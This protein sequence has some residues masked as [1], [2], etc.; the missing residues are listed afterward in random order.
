MIY[1][2]FSVHLSLKSFVATNAQI[3]QVSKNLFITELLYF[4]GDTYLINYNA[5]FSF[6]NF[7]LF[8]LMQDLYFYAVHF[9]MHNYIYRIHVL[10]H[11]L[12][13][14]YYAWYGSVYEHIF[15]N[16]GSVGIPFMIFP[17]SS[18]CFFVIITLQ[19]YTSVNGHTS[20]SPHSIHHLHPKKRLGSIYLIDRL[21][22][23]Y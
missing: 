12:Y 5:S 6:I 11:S 18:L 7:I 23:T 1:L 10:H 4:L 14:P 20:D 13:S 17:N 8:I 3:L 15:L 21:L 19:T 16:L 22:G 2:Y 9:I